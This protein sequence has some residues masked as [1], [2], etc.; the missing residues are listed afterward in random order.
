MRSLVSKGGIVATT[1]ALIEGLA[2][3]GVAAAAPTPPTPG[4]IGDTLKL[5]PSLQV[6]APAP[7]VTQNPRR[8]NEAPAG[9]EASITVSHFTLVGNTLFTAEQLAPL[10]ADFL[11]R[12]ITLAQLYEAADRITD[13]YVAHGYTLGSA[14]VPAQTVRDGEVTLRIIEGRIGEIRF[15]NNDDYTDQC[16]LAF[17]THTQPGNVYRSDD[18]QHDLF[19]LN[20][21][22]GLK[23][24]AVLTPGTEFGTSDIVVKT[25]QKHFDVDAGIDNYGRK[26]V[27]EYRYSLGLTLNNPGRIGDQVQL[28]VLHSNTDRLNYGSAAYNAPIGHDGWRVGASY[29]RA[30]FDVDYPFYT[31]GKNETGSLEANKTWLHTA[32]TVAATS[33]GWMFTNADVD[34][35]GLPFSATGV[36]LVTL[37]ANGSQLWRNGAFSQLVGSVH[38]DF[39][40]AT[41][42]NHNHERIRLELN[43]QHLQP[44]PARLQILGELDGVYS[45]DPLADT[46]QMSIGGPT[47][48]RGFPPTEVRGDRGWYARATLRRPF[49]LGAFALIPRVFADTGAVNILDHAAGAKSRDSL[50]GAGAGADLDYRQ[51]SLHIDW[52]Y[53]LDSTPVSDNRDDGRVY[54]SLAASF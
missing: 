49:R 5:S 13:Y 26:D 10:L 43:A 2:C 48:V 44:L 41:P 6:P 1:A 54:L 17:M 8:T 31:A 28:L 18:L 4:S 47:T 46:E 25:A 20:D 51:Y 19:T 33:I 42:E 21:L 27:G 14:M 11:N 35:S 16:L 40:Q 50:S 15:E 37:G 38:T 32:T 12:P 34:L 39:R 52:A 53:P 22:P 45:P 29:G 24:R 3:G 36:H 9:D 23:T 30:L 7:E